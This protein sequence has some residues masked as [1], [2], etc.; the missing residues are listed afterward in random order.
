MRQLTG[1]LALTTAVAYLWQ[2]AAWYRAVIVMSAVPIALTANITRVM[3]TGYIMHFFT[4]EYALGT[5]HTVEGLLMMG[6]GL[7]LLNVECWVL[8]RFDRP[9]REARDPEE[10]S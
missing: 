8:D 10:F 5:F 7:L 4:P 2:R 3:L 9:A 1:F 6:F